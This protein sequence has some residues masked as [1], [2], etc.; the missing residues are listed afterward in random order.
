M[1]NL[2][3][4]NSLNPEDTTEFNFVEKQ[5]DFVNNCV[6]FVEKQIEK[7]LLDRDLDDCAF[8]YYY[9]SITDSFKELKEINKD[10]I[11]FLEFENDLER[12]FMNAVYTEDSNSAILGK[13]YFVQS[14]IRGL[15]FT[16]N[17]SNYTVVDTVFCYMN[18]LGM[19]YPLSIN[20]DNYNK[21]LNKSMEYY[22]EYELYREAAKLQ[23][24]LEK[25]KT[26][27]SMYES[28]LEQVNS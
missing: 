16:K 11:K 25:L 5:L 26:L 8:K 15:D 1:N 7:L 19:K 9:D 21:I 12:D 13:A 6:T 27:T 14:A 23:K 3:V 17:F 10:F 20:F 2:P 28:I 18:T 22:L 24:V 4:Y